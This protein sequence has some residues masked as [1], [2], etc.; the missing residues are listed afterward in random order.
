MNTERTER[1]E[2]SKNSY[3]F[4]FQIVSFPNYK[5]SRWHSKP[6]QAKL[7]VKQQACWEPG[8][9]QANSLASKNELRLEGFIDLRQ[10]VMI[11]QPGAGTVLKYG[12][13][14]GPWVDTCVPFLCSEFFSLGRLGEVRQTGLSNLCRNKPEAPTEQTDVRRGAG[15]V[16][17]VVIVTKDGRFWNI[18]TFLVERESISRTIGKEFFNF[19]M[20]SLTCGI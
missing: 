11:F 12:Q 3:V 16:G 10:W 6:D 19:F 5:F 7:H 14:L 1:G 15:N 18:C 4:V 20:L 13:K 8:N 2:R 17:K 9:S